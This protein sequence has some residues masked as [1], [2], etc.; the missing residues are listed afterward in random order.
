[1]AQEKIKF[2]DV[3]IFQPD[4]DVGYAWETTYTEDSGRVV[5]G[6][7]RISPLFTVEAFTFSFTNIPVKEMSKILKIVAKGK[8]FKM[9][10]FSP[11]YAEWR[12]DTFY[13]GQGDTSLGSLKENDE[14]F[15][16][17]TIKATGVNPI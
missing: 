11:Y 15:T 14:I 10:Y 9:H 2:N 6:K 1:M 3:V 13:V 17:A 7:A 5:S 12:N 8:P 4:K 16:S